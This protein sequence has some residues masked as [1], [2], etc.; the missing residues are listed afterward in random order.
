[1]SEQMKDTQKGYLYAS[2]AVLIWTGFIL[3]SRMG[4]ISDLGPYDV[5]AIRYLTC[6]CLLLPVWWFKYRFNLLNG[7][8]I[9]ASLVGGLAYALCTFRGFQLS[10][11]SHAAVLLPGLMPLF[12]ILLSALINKKPQ[13]KS[14]YLGVVIITLG[15]G[16]MFY[17]Q[18]SA[19][20]NFSEGHL[21]LI[22]GAFCWSLFSVLISRWNITPWEATVSL[23]FIT[24]ILY[25]PVYIAYLPKSI[26][27]EWWPDILLQIFYQG[28]L[29]TIVQM[30]FYVKAVQSIGP[31]SMGAMMAAVPVLS[32]VIALFLF[33]EL[34]STELVAG[35][36]LVSIGAWLTHSKLF[37]AKLI[38][39]NA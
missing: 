15:V 11:A 2:V 17:Q 39:T 6:T 8:L 3:V 34:I 10:P 20:R 21:W 7:K 14:K 12:I 35:L 27:S 24:C 18:F 29:A 9:V 28:V 37:Q 31:A 36:I 5:I 25:L 23:A 30:I 16:A 13:D 1:M 33:N 4:G 19:T 22:A 26:S 32:G 38:S